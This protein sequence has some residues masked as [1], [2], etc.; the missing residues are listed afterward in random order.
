MIDQIRSFIL[1]A[2]FALLPLPMRSIEAT[3]F[4]LAIGLQ[5]SQFEVRFQHGGPARGFW[6]FEIAGVRGVLEHPQTIVPIGEACETLRYPHTLEAVDLHLALTHNDILAACFARCLLWTLPE[7]LPEPDQAVVAWS[8]YRRTWRPGTPRVEMWREN[9][10]AGWT[11]AR[12]IRT[13]ND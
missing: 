1:P 6:Q 12:E 5:E 2:A 8:Q 11:L 3:A 4:L 10:A 13:T 7:K 9:Y